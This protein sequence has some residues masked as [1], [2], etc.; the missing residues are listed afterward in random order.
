MAHAWGAVV[1]VTQFP[2]KR[3][4]AADEPQM[5]GD[6]ASVIDAL[7]SLPALNKLVRYNEF[8]DQIEI[9]SPPPWDGMD[10]GARWTDNSTTLLMA[11]IQNAGYPV[12]V[13]RVIDAAVEIA[14]RD[15]AYHPVVQYLEA[16][17]AIW[18]GKPRLDI[19]FDLYFGAEGPDDYLK[20]VSRGFAI[21]AVARVMQ[22]GAKVDTVPVL[23]GPQGS[24]KSTA[25]RVLGEPWNSENLPPLGD[26]EA[27]LALQGVWIAEISELAAMRRS[28]IEQVKAFL[29]R[30]VDHYRVPYKAHFV[31]RPRQTVLVGTTNEATY[32]KDH[33]GNRRFW[34]V[35]CTRID[36]D[37]LAR[38]KVQIWGEAVHAYK[39]GEAWHLT[40]D[41]EKLAAEAQEARRYVPEL[42]VQTLDYLDRMREQGHDTLEMR[43]VIRAVSGVDSNDD[44]QRAGAI[45]SQVAAI[46]A[47]HD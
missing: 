46:M 32:L 30:T 41:A 9:A 6:E 1:T 27:A 34:P 12:R 8:S 13:R 36:T 20:A 21:G 10:Y 43:A 15:H 38:D 33:T 31:Q 5:R 11:Y 16:C 22:P 3:R 39:A 17:A 23:E 26:K 47:R 18:D 14:A 24:G 2:K 4:K 40:G 45:G 19:L 28:E 42:E 25:V 37:A 35:R 44:P 7:R 29:S